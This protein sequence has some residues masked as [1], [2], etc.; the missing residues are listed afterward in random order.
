M[1]VAFVACFILHSES[2]FHTKRK[3]LQSRHSNFAGGV[4]VVQAFRSPVS[5]GLNDQMTFQSSLFE[6]FFHSLHS[7]QA[8]IRVIKTVDAYDVSACKQETS[9]QADITMIVVNQEVT[10][11]IVL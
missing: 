10:L 1:C 7:F 3:L 8:H 6:R 4:V 9:G 5:H 11:E 2:N